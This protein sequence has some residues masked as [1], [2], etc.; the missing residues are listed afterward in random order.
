MSYSDYDSDGY[1]SNDDADYV[2]SADNLSED[3]LNDCVKEDPLDEN[4]GVPLVSD[5]S[6]KKKRTKKK[7]DSLAMRWVVFNLYL[8]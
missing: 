8:A 5:G 3:D 2:P 6:K 1:S 7:D 4:D